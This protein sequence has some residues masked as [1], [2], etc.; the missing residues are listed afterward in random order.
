MQN[1]EQNNKHNPFRYINRGEKY[2]SINAIFCISM[3]IFTIYNKSHFVVGIKTSIF[4]YWILGILCSL[5][6]KD[7]FF[8]IPVIIIRFFGF[9]RYFLIGYSMNIEKISLSKFDYEWMMIVEM[10][11]TYIVFFVYTYRHPT[12]KDNALY[13]PNKEYISA[14]KYYGMSL[15]AVLLIGSMYVTINRT[16]LIKYFTLNSGLAIDFSN[17]FVALII[18]SFFSIFYIKALIFIENRHSLCRIFKLIAELFVSILFV[19]GSNLTSTSVSRWSFLVSIIIVYMFLTRMHPEYKKKLTV[20]LMAS[21]VLI[22][23][24]SS[25]NK[26]Q[27]LGASGYNTMNETTKTLF[28]YMNLN[29]YCSGPT[30]IINGMKTIDYVKVMN[31]SKIKIFISDVFNNFPL[32]NKFLVDVNLTSPRLFNF[33]LYRT[34]E[35]VDQ[36]MPL[37]VQFYNFFG[38]LY[39]VPEMILVYMALDCYRKTLYEKDFIRIYYLIYLSFTFSLINNINMTVMFQ[40]IWIQILPMYLIYIFNYRIK[41]QHR[42]RGVNN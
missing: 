31:I 38:I 28:S 11:T 29:A 23:L 18:S 13:I 2:R 14:N 17:G 27:M 33:V 4:I 20:L 35:F 40:N 30:N 24:V 10:I 9:I 39:F 16:I 12:F 5:L 42:K 1:K 19:N 7:T 36:I 15:I 41:Y 25:L 34:R 22:T 3:L 37:S 32:L 6:T 8:S 26:F 21:G